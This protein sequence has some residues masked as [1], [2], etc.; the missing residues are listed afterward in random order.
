MTDFHW[1]FSVRGVIT[2]MALYVFVY[3]FLARAVLA[4]ISRKIP[5]YYDVGDEEGKLPLGMATSSAIWEMLFDSDM[6]GRDFGQFV[7]FGLYA[8]RVMLA[9]YL[10]LVGFLLYEA[11]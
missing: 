2:I 4:S 6:P 5:R 8:A 11:S 3:H 10:P 1:P 9:C 7:Q